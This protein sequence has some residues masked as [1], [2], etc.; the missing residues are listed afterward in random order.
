MANFTNIFMWLLIT[1]IFYSLSITIMVPLIPDAQQNQIVMYLSDEGIINFNS[2]SASVEGAVESQS[3]IPFLDYGS[4]IFYSTSIILNLLINFFTAIPQMV[5]MLISTLFIFL[6]FDYS[7]QTTIKM[8]F[9]IVIN[10]LYYISLLFYITN[11]R[12]SSG[13]N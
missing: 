9:F 13:V 10:A 5:L 6:P 11:Q 4:L 2:L 1:Q 7:I 8:I 3:S 12:T